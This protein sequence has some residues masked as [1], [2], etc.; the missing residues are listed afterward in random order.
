L[1]FPFF[2]ANRISFSPERKKSI[3]AS[4]L[5]LATG[6]VALGVAVMV[7]SVSIVTGFQDE[8]H[9][10][11]VGFMAH[12]TVHNLDMNFTHETMPTQK[13]Q[14]FYPGIADIEGIRHI[15][16]YATKPGII[17]TRD[18][19]Q[20]IVMKGIDADFDWSFLET[21][22]IKGK[23][24]A[25]TPDKKVKDILISNIASL[26]N[27][28]VGNKLIVYFIQTGKDGATKQPRPRDFR[29]TGIYETGFED[30]DKNFI[31]CDI[32]HIQKIQGWSKK[33][34]KVVVLKYSLMILTNLMK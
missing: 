32:K 3:A 8:I 7:I 21:S 10:K 28:D 5:K 9:K 12:I 31:F 30:F 16:V 22:I 13:N 6:A 1:N 26:L 24:F 23:K 19:I 29:I 34:E 20:G 17:K 18:E 11:V 4:V 33:E 14:P 25:I 27:L 15:Q 2:I